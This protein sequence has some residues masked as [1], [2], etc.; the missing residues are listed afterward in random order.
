MQVIVSGAIPI[1]PGILR[2][3]LYTLTE[4]GI[5][6]DYEITVLESDFIT[7]KE[8]GEVSVD[9]DQL[10]VLLSEKIVEMQFTANLAS[11]IDNADLSWELKNDTVPNNDN[12]ENTES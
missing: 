5:I 8:N 2:I 12:T 3:A 1:K 11:A 9:L 4:D 6:T 7:H 10:K